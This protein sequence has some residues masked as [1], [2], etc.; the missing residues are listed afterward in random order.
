MYNISVFSSGKY[1]YTLGVI[2][3]EAK[4]TKGKKMAI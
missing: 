4:D 2:S 1:K 3:K